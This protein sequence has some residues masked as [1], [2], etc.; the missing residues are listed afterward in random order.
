[1]QKI[2]I[3]QTYP[4]Q[5]CEAA[6]EGGE[7][8]GYIAAVVDILHNYAS[9]FTVEQAKALLD[10]ANRQ[11]QQDPGQKITEFSNSVV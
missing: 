1:M 9:C 3:T 8:A 2:T 11:V 6:F 7:R 4:E 5:K 10:S